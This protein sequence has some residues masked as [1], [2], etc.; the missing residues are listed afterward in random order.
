MCGKTR[1]SLSS[2]NF[3]SNQLFSKNIAFTKFLSKKVWKYRNFHAVKNNNALPDFLKCPILPLYLLNHFLFLLSYKSEINTLR[4]CKLFLRNLIQVSS[5]VYKIFNRTNYPSR[6]FTCVIWRFAMKIFLPYLGHVGIH[7]VLW[8][9]W[10]AWFVFEKNKSWW[11]S[12]IK[13]IAIFRVTKTSNLSLFFHELRADNWV[14][15]HRM[16]SWVDFAAAS[17][18]RLFPILS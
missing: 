1:N 8:I 17:S 11:T 10:K 2:K 3:L 5:S 9:H 16:E 12:S 18:Q 6:W 15:P 14:S 7:L 4:F 13:N